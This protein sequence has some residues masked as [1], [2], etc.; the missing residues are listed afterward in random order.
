MKKITT[1]S[2]RVRHPPPRKIIP[3]LICVCFILGS[4]SFA[5]NTS[6]TIPKGIPMI[7]K[8]RAVIAKKEKRKSMK[9]GIPVV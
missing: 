2:G 7:I 4:K 1:I 3:N 5:P 6:I 9:N 8:N